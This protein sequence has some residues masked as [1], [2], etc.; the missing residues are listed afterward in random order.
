MPQCDR[1]ALP[2]LI[3]GSADL[4]GSNNT[5]WKGC[6][7]LTRESPGNYMHYGVREFGM[8]AAHERHRVARWVHSVFGDVP[9]VH[10]IRAQR[11]A[12]GVADGGSHVL[13]Y[14][15][16]SVGLGEDGPTHQPIEQLTN[17]RTT[18]KLSVW[19]PCER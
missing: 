5:D 13:V 14:T 9:D 17:L 4:T 11:G 6:K 19:R 2:E 7:V 12:A 15:H 16:D 3:G 8:T 18:P 10:G 1:P